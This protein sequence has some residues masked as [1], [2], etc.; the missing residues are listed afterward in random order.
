M[1]PTIRAARFQVQTIFVNHTLRSFSGFSALTL[2]PRFLKLNYKM[3]DATV[4][5]NE[6]TA[7]SWI[8]RPARIA[9]TPGH[10]FCGD[11]RGGIPK[12]SHFQGWKNQ[13]R[14]DLP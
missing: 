1:I 12:Q 6:R 11:V 14:L 9:I 3:S 2:C 8:L 4:A 5:Q 13:L 7:N 10:S